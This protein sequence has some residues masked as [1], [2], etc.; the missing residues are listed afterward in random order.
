MSG[1]ELVRHTPLS[2]VKQRMPAMVK[3]LPGGNQSMVKRFQQA[4]I[5]V[6]QSPGVANCTPES[7]VKAVYE[8]ARL[9]LIPD[10][11]LHLAYVVPFKEHGV[12]KAT[13]IV[14]YKGLIELARR[15]DPALHIK[16]GTVYSNDDYVLEEGLEDVFRIVKPWWLKGK[17]KGQPVFFYCISK[18][19]NGQPKLTIVPV[20]DA[21]EIANKSRAGNKPGRPW[22]DHF[23]RMGEKTALRR[24]SR[25]W[26]LD[27]DREDTRRFREALEYDERS[28]EGHDVTEST[29]D[30]MGEDFGGD[31]TAGLEAGN[32]RM[33]SVDQPRKPVQNQAAPPPGEERDADGPPNSADIK[34]LDMLLE[35]RLVDAGRPDADPDERYNLQQAAAAKAGVDIPRDTWTAAHFGRVFLAL[36]ALSPSD[37]LS[38]IADNPFDGQP[39]DQEAASE[40]GAE[41]SA[42]AAYADLVKRWVAKRGCPEDVAI[43]AINTLLGLKYS[44]M[45]AKTLSEQAWQEVGA[46]VDAGKV[47]WGLYEP[48]TL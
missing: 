28:D 6:A 48:K 16:L 20:Q 30:L 14:G 2:L 35:Q 4:A 43:K 44:G 9:N 22:H 36:R 12:A 1:N 34:K 38:A 25:T 29:E 39:G 19:T 31:E 10:P 24:A 8:C 40:A 32:R 27:P 18:Q 15:A 45:N 5:G 47:K 37:V 41:W 33:G 26:S 42:S 11:V 17:E 23:E 7:V 3:S 21:Q 46:A 13:L